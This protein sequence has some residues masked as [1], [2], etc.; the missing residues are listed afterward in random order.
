MNN[1]IG[2]I[3]TGWKNNKLKELTADR[4]SAAVPIGGKYRAIDFTLSN[5]VNSNI[6]KVA[7]MTQYNFRSLI[8]HL[9]SGKEWDL[10]RRNDGLYIF[11]PSMTGDDV[12][13][14]RGT[15]D[16]LY[17]NMSFFKRSNEEFVII[18]QGNC[19][20]KMNFGKMLDYHIKN[21]AD[22]TVA[23]REMNDFLPDE[24][25]Q[26]GILTISQDQRI[27]DFYEK[28]AN[29]EFVTGSM[30]IYIVKRQLLMALLE[31]SNAHG[32]YDFVK[33][34]IIKKLDK[35]KVMGYRFDGYFRNMST[36]NMYF[37]CNMELLNPVLRH[38]LFIENG[39]VYTK[40]KDETPAKYNEEADV[41]NSV[42]A[43]GCIIEGKV[44]NSILFR[45]V[46]VKKGAVIKDSII[47]QSSIIEENAAIEYAILD[48]NV[49]L[50]E[51]KHL[52]GDRNWPVVI[53]KN[54]VV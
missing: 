25:S 17:R 41:T 49:T 8:D 39:K 51:N 9:G 13:W 2:I 29:P 16:T 26:L 7:V 31:E 1:I 3:L 37:R 43:D 42:V 52:K 18:S 4:S 14:Y 5:M 45:G 48:K 27:T 21:N 50:S 30:G 33:D 44:E 53:G 19:V 11:P 46:T 24:L 36:I 15:A 10:D 38:D 54:S 23:Y 12:S 32:D 40:V 20:Y 28:P 22:I 34:I 47:M 6:T 35:L